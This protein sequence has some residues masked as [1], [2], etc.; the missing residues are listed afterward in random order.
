MNGEHREEEV[1]RTQSVT[2]PSWKIFGLKS[3][4]EKRR[5]DQI[6]SQS[7][8]QLDYGIETL[9]SNSSV[10]LSKPLVPTTCAVAP[11][12]TK[13]ATDTFV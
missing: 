1:H 7:K 5:I 2:D 4:P 10:E 6:R 3:S 12:D 9:V 8:K 13:V 11:T